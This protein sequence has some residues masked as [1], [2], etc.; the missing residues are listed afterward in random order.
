V[1]AVLHEREGIVAV[2]ELANAV[3]LEAIRLRER[4]NHYVTS[5]IDDEWHQRH[6]CTDTLSS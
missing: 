2:L 3:P 5:V 4:V 6:W 1:Q